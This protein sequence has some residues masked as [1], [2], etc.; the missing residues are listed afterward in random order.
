MKINKLFIFSLP[1]LFILGSISHFVYEFTGKLTI[2]GLFFPVNESIYEHTKLAIVPL[3]LFYIY[4]LKNKPNIT[5]WICCFLVSL[6]ITILL[7]PMLY[8]FYTGSFGFESVIVD[9]IIY[10]ISISCGQMLSLH[11]Y[12]RGTKFF[13]IKLSGVIIITYF[14]LNIIFTVDPPHLPIFFDQVSNTYG[15]NN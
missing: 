4:G 2:I 6:I 13:D 8:Y 10:F 1:V 12:N 3:L 5:K 7:I 9:V 11:V 14:I 15:I